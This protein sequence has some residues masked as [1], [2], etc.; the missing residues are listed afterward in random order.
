MQTN[1]YAFCYSPLA[2][3]ASETSLFISTE[4]LAKYL[5]FLSIFKVLFSPFERAL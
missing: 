3:N 5:W 4:I 2:D 1:L